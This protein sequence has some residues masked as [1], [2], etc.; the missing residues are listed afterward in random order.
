MVENP[1]GNPEVAD[2]IFYEEGAM[3]YAKQGRI[4]WYEAHRTRNFT[5]ANR[6]SRDAW[7]QEVYFGESPD[8][9]TPEGE[10]FDLL[11]RERQSQYD[12]T[13]MY[14]RKKRWEWVW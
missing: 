3:R 9:Y 4:F 5:F 7:S 10:F 13:V 12:A 14:K 2:D 8:G 11:V 1:D 6:A